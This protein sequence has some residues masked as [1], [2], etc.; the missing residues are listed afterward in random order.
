MPNGEGVTLASGPGEPEL[1]GV[2]VGNGALR[3]QIGKFKFGVGVG[4]GS[5]VG[6]IT[7]GLGLNLGGGM[8]VGSGSGGMRG[9][10]KRG[11]SAALITSV[12]FQFGPYGEALFSTGA[13]VTVI[14]AMLSSRFSVT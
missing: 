8:G 2:A 10:G 1:I 13:G 11:S 3:R 5:V 6:T 14:G 12:R 4:V 7:I 9:S